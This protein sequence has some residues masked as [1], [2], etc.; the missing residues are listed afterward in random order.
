V[1]L[2]LYRA[3]T[4]ETQRADDWAQRTLSCLDSAWS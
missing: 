1:G 4:G 3:R 2:L